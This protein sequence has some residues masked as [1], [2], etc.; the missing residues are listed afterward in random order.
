MAN[1]P[2]APAQLYRSLNERLENSD[3]DGAIELYY[4]L[5]SSGRSV[6]EI[7][8]G[9]GPVR[10]ASAQGNSVAA[11]QARSGHS[12]AQT[13]ITAE[14]AVYGRFAGRCAMDPRPG[15]NPR[16]KRLQHGKTPKR[17]AR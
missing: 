6:G 12:E 1:E 16:S 7:L 17:A 14:V 9:V 13:G 11:E 15:R 4:E 3:K 5:L 2:D 10:G 8:N